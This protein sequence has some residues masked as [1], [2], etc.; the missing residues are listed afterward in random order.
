MKTPEGAAAERA[1]A[2]KPDHWGDMARRWRQLGPPLRPSPEDIAFCTD[3]V[4]R[5]VRERGAPRVL[6]LGV[7]PELYHMP[8]PDGTDF[9]AVDHTQAMIDAV[10]PGPK[11]AV[12][13]TDWR[14]IA[15]LV[16]RRPATEQGEILGRDATGVERLDRS[17]A[18]PWRD[19]VLCDGGLHLLP[20]PAEQRRLVETLQHVL[21]ADGLCIF[22]LFLP[23]ED[24]EPSS[25]ILEDFVKGRISSLNVLKFRMWMSLQHDAA[26]GVALSTVWRA[27]H[28]AAGDFETLA[29]AIGWSAEHM[30][31]INAYRDSPSR[32]YFATL[33]EVK[34]LFCEGGGFEVTRTYEPAYELGAQCPT[35]VFRRARPR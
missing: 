19:V 26:E 4:G 25:A 34:D 17:R 2:D 27:V 9:L 7:T 21:A 32:Y 6:L 3:A 11:D 30:L 20:Y 24:R 28:E 33:G 8:W 18:K 35:I 22:R 14:E 1:A 10:W 29:S 16:G 13:C 31:A 5:W 12:R 23:F 15:H